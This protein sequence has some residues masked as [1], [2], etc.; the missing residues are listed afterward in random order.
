MVKERLEDDDVDET[1]CWLPPRVR[2]DSRREG[3]LEREDEGMA[4]L[5]MVWSSTALVTVAMVEFT[6][7][8]VFQQIGRTAIA[9]SA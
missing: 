2:A 1:A 8:T 6:L 9:G 7:H 3:L 4:A 5:D